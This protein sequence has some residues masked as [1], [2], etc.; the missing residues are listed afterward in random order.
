MISQKYKDLAKWAMQYALSKGCSDVRV[1]VNAGTSNS[2]EYRDTQLD[3]LEQS[4]E[5]GMTIQLFVDGRYASYSTNRMEKK[6]LEKYIA[7]GVETT[8]FL[9]PDEFRKLPQP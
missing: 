1:S 8:R 4:S 7:N 3:K 6:E 5:N 2:F 9:A